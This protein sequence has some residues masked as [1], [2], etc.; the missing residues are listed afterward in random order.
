MDETLDLTACLP[1]TKNFK[2]DEK[3]YG[4][5]FDYQAILN[6]EK[7]YGSAKSALAT[8]HDKSNIYENTV[9]FLYAGLAGRYK[10]TKQEIESWIGMGTINILDRIIF[11]ALI[12]SYGVPNNDSEEA[13]EGEV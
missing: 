10:I 5:I 6:L 13:D 12:L 2:I 7:I 11:E 1:Q 8:F 4:L 9:N 3:E